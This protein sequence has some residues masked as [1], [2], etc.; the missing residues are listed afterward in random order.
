MNGIVIEIIP[1]RKNQMPRPVLYNKNSV[2]LGRAFDCDIIIDDPY[3]APRHIEISSGEKGLQIKDLNT[4]NG[5]K[6]HKSL[7]L[8]E[9]HYIKSGDEI[10][11]GRTK[12]KIY[13]SEHLIEPEKRIG[14]STFTRMALNRYLQ[15]ILLFV[16]AFAM[17]FAW[18]WYLSTDKD[19]LKYDGVTI[20]MS[21]PIVFLTVAL[22]IAFSDFIMR[23][24]FR[25]SLA[26]SLLSI[27]VIFF[28]PLEFPITF[29][30]YFIDNYKTSVIVEIFMWSS[31]LYF[32]LL[33]TNLLYKDQILKRDLLVNL[34]IAVTVVT[35]GYLEDIPIGY[36][37]H[38]RYS[39]ILL[40]KAEVFVVGETVDEFIDHIGKSGF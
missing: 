35:I 39:H 25:L 34:L 16:A 2:T 40:P 6:H 31:F 29:V 8:N 13:S 7:I 20:L 19:F 1:N 37:P 10:L 36:D 14:F 26:V 4:I 24:H 18:E 17:F 3:I 11:I 21:Y 28:I 5:V 27:F 12:V 23:H 22:F 32:F 38:P 15:A 30:S 33:A 9:K